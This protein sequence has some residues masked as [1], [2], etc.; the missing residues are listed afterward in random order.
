MLVFKFTRHTPCLQSVYDLEAMSG[1]SLDHNSKDLECIID[2][3]KRE[4]CLKSI[5]VITGGSEMSSAASQET[6]MCSEKSP[7][8]EWTMM[9]E[10][11]SSG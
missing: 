11:C 7:M 2:K 9:T 1:V 3:K 4:K 8:S 6:R 5:S 10:K